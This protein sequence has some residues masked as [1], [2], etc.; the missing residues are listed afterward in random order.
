MP[1]THTMLGLFQY[2]CHQWEPALKNCRK[3]V[4][5]GALDGRSDLRASIWLIRAQTGKEADASRELETYLQSAQ[6]SKTNDWEASVARFFSGSLTESNFLDQATTTARRPSAIREQ[7]CESLYYAGM[8][9][10]IAG[11]KHGALEFF[12]RC[13]DT[14]DNNNLAYLNAATEM[15]A[16]TDR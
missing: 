7:V 5:M 9:H 16:L 13:V 10:K 1:D 6:G 8:K 4:E 2:R 11:D 15:R 14:K 12:Q 3:A